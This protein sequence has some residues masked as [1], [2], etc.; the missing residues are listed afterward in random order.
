MWKTKEEFNKRDWFYY[1]MGM[2]LET[3]RVKGVTYYKID[4]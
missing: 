1:R 2:L 4:E 3:K